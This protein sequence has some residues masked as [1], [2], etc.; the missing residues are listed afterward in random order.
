MI[1]A[2]IEEKVRKGHKILAVLIDPDEYDQKRLTRLFS[3]PAISGIDLILV[4][5]SLLHGAGIEKTIDLIKD[6]SNTPVILF[7]GNAIQLTRK[8]DALLL[9]SLV[10]GRNAEFLIGQQVIAAPFLKESG[11]EVISTAYLLIDGGKPTTASYISG[12]Q[13]IPI[14]K[15][16]ITGTTAL[17]ASYIGMK[18]T[19]LDAGSGAQKPVPSS[20]IS[21]ARRQIRGPLITGGG[22]RT[23]EQLIE[24]YRSGADIAVVGN[25]L[26]EQPETLESFVFAKEQFLQSIVK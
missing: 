23:E 3:N 7:P 18:W 22:I 10:S 17:A 24:A 19:Y 5:G 25:I 14:D 20:H 13:P 2:G 16:A 21:A 9:L 8:A 1:S 26:E 4:G 15:P 6:L 11:L 12:E